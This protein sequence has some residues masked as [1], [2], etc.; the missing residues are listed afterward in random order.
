MSGFSERLLQ[1]LNY[2]G[3]SQADLARY[4]NVRQ[5]TIQT[6]IQ[7]GSIPAADTAL[8]V[9]R[10]L[11][12]SLEYLITGKNPPPKEEK[13][14]REN[15][16]FLDSFLLLPEDEQNEIKDLIKIKMKKYAKATEKKAMLFDL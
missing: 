13:I 15:L 10:F 3:F 7:K 4:L 6:W 1:E 12:I 2:L 16:D 8:K 9:A 5:S 11:N 14:S